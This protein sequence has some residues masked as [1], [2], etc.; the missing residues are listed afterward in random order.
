MK[1]FSFSWSSAK[2]ILIFDLVSATHSENMRRADCTEIKFRQSFS[3]RGR[4]YI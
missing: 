1:Q 3:G 4:L 2:L